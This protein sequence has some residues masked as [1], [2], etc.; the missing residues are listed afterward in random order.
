MYEKVYFDLAAGLILFTIVI[1]LQIR[2]MTKGMANRMFLHLVLFCVAASVLDMSRYFIDGNENLP[3]WVNYAVTILFFAV[4]NF[5]FAAYCF[6]IVSITDMWHKARSA[7]QFYVMPLPFLITIAYS[8][9]GIF[10]EIPYSFDANGYFVAGSGIWL[11]YICNEIYGVY[12]VVSICIYR[13]YLGNRKALALLSTLLA[14]LGAYLITQK[15]PQFHM[16]MI[17]FSLGILFVMIVVQNP[18]V[19][20]DYQ[21]GLVRH[22]AYFE[23]MTRAFES[24]KPMTVLMMDI[25]NFKEL[26]HILSY[27]K[28]TSFIQQISS[29]MNIINDKLK[30]SAELYYIKNGKFRVVFSG[31]DSKTI[32]KAAEAFN[33]LFNSQLQLEDMTIELKSIV[34]IVRC[35]QNFDNMDAFQD[36]DGSLLEYENDGLV[37]TASDVLANDEYNV[38]RHLN[39]IIEN[40]LLNGGFEVYYQP[41]LNVHTHKF[42][43][44]EALLRL[45]DPK[46]GYIYPEV[47]IPAAEKNG[48]IHR[49]GEFVINEVCKF[50]SSK[51]FEKLSVDYISI[52]LSA[53]QCLKRDFPDKV[54]EIITSHQ[55]SPKRICF[56]L[57]ESSATD[58]QKIFFENIEKME[59]SGIRFALDDFGSGYSNITTFAH[60]SFS[61]IKF[62]KLFVKNYL[63]SRYAAILQNYMEMAKDLGKTIVIEGVETKE[64]AEY[65]SKIGCDNIQGFYYSL[66]N[67]IDE[68]VGFLRSIDSNAV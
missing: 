14:S 60:S 6:Y 21:S 12:A 15:F 50:I 3:I 16:D 66:A 36:F 56:E 41:I 27:N 57:T 11:F 10:S 34:C 2:R 67:Q 9:Y 39:S 63:N 48:S 55:I 61:I 43:S 54:S 17:L 44:A 53:L 62:D 13:K 31:V 45:Y 51:D 7:F 65:F 33:N 32:V 18:E 38:V 46:Y 49:M 4:R 52:N 19:R 1:S 28:V 42:D 30:L 24:E 47:F 40:A 23:E 59:K 58:S 29:R 22:A 37:V 35:P 64:E 8:I 25:R 5:S 68:Y 20:R 26:S